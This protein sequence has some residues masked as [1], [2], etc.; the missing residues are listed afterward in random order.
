MGFS[1]GAHDTSG[2]LRSS[3][4]FGLIGHQFGRAANNHAPAGLLERIETVDLESEAITPHRRVELAAGVGSE[5]DHVVYHRVVD[6][7]HDRPVLVNECEPTQMSG[8]EQ[9]P[10][11]VC[12][13]NV[14]AFS[15][16]L[17]HLHYQLLLLRTTLSAPVSA[18]RENTS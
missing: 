11:F 10:A 7:Q 16:H 12:V 13:E 9:R 8:L 17:A 14:P 15:E 1:P 4:E 2:M 5:Y 18:A 3:P 6:G